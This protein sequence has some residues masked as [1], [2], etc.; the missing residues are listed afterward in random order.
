MAR[1]WTFGGLWPYAPHW[2]DAEKAVTPE[3][4]TEWMATA[5][6]A[7]D[8]GS[9]DAESWTAFQ[10]KI[11]NALPMIGAP[12]S[13]ALPL[14]L[15]RAWTTGV[16]KPGTRALLLGMETTKWIYAGAIVGWAALT[17]AA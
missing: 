10:G 6:A 15:D 3:A 2:F 11:F 7:V 5:A 13:A 9:A 8:A 1:D 4:D 12:G 14:G 17:P 16:V